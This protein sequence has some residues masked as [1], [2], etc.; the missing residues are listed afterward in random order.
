[1]LC[2]GLGS[3]GGSDYEDVGAV[4][5]IGKK[6]EMTLIHKLTPHST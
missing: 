5:K 2:D 3:H 1:M 6:I 4:F